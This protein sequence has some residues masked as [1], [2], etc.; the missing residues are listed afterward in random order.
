L[1]ARAFRPLPVRE[2]RIP[3]HGGKLR[4]LGIPT[5]PAYCRVVQYA[6]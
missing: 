4:R 3:K 1:Q 2:R 6:V 5:V